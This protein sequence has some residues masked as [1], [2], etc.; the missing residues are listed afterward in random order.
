MNNFKGL[1]RHASNAVSFEPGQVIFSE[2]DPGDVM[3]MVQEGEVE[4]VAHGKLVEIAGEGSIV[5]EMAL[6]DN[7]P[8]SATV[9]AKTETKL[10]PVDQKQFSFMVQETPFFAIHVMHVMA[11]RLRKRRD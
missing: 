5:G 9:T 8:R 4:I 3:Y 10:V 2:G 6:V 7:E 1:F 11:D